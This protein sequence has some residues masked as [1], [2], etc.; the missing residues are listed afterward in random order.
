MISAVSVVSA[1]SVVSAGIVSAPSLS[2]SGQRK[3]DLVALGLWGFT[4][5]RG[6]LVEAVELALQREGLQDE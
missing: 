3:T 4:T 5:G 2:C 6:W 1:A